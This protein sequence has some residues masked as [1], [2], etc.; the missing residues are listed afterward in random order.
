MDL[1]HST[2]LNS[3]D[4]IGEKENKTESFSSSTGPK[5]SL[6]GLLTTIDIRS[7]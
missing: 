2:G 3:W 6:C 5:G 4:R 7:K 1:G